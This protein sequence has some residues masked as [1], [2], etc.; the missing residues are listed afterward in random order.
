MG[1]DKAFSENSIRIIS[2]TS[3]VSPGDYVTLKADRAFPNTSCL[4][5]VYDKYGKVTGNSSTSDDEGY[6]S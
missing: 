1:F 3:P 5:T 6:L 2:I 4:V